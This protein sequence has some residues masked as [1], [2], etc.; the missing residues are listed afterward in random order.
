[1]IGQGAP[2]ART[3]AADDGLHL[4]VR[5][6]QA[7]QPLVLILQQVRELGPGGVLIVHHDR[8]PLLLYPE[9]VQIG[10]W[11]DRIPG[12]PGEVRLRLAAAS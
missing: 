7:P 10:W 9:L 6:L 1:M 3:W 4:D 11:A 8:D 5:G 2:A 12:D